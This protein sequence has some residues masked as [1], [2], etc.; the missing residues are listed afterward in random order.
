MSYRFFS[1]VWLALPWRLRRLFIR[2]SHGS[3]TASAAAV[4]INSEEKVLALRHFLRPLPWGLPGGF[5]DGGEQPAEAIR[6]ELREEVGVELDDV[7]L[8][9]LRTIGRHIE[10]LFS[11]R[12]DDEPQIISSEIQEAGWYKLDELPD[13]FPTDQL[14]VVR[15]V[16]GGEV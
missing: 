12:S 7:R 16:L 9:Q 11:A 10:I 6:R 1:R 5:I 14:K 4:V 2:V 15:R 8:L 13:G 3:F